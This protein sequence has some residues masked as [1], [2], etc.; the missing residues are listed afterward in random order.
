M[1]TLGIKAAAAVLLGSVLSL[2]PLPFPAAAQTA[3]SSE[4]PVIVSQDDLPRRFYPMATTAAEL[5]SA[6]DATFAAWAM[7]VAADADATLGGYVIDDPATRRRLLTTRTAAEMIAG[8]NEAALKSLLEARALEQK[9]DQRLT[10]GLTTEAVLRARLETGAAAG[11]AFQA[12]FGRHLEAALA[13]LPFAVV[14][15]ALKEMKSSAEIQSPS[16]IAGYVETEV[17][18]AVT[19]SGGLSYTGADDLLWARTATR[20]MWPV[21]DATVAALRKVITANAVQKPDIWAARDL[22]L[23]GVGDLTPVVAAVWDSGVDTALFPGQLYAPPAPP[24]RGLGNGHGLSFDVDSNPT[25][26]VLLPLTPEQAKAYPG[27]IADFQGFADNRAAIDSPAAERLRAKLAAMPAGET[28]AYFEQMNFFG[29]YLHGT[30]VAGILARDNPAL[31]LAVIRDTYDTRP[32]PAP[33][34]DETTAA[35]IAAFSD[36]SAWLKAN[37]VRVVNMSWIDKPDSY[38]AVLEKNGIGRDQAERKALARR[39]FERSRD[40]FVRLLA[41][42]PAT[43]FVSAAGNSDSD[44]AFEEG[45]PSSLVAPNLIIASAVDQAGDETSFTSNGRNVAVTANGYQ[46]VSWVPGGQELAESGTSMASPNVAN[47]A[48][49]LIALRPSLTPEQTIALIR[50]GATPSADGRR[51]NIN[52]QASAALLRAMPTAGR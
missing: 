5:L 1:S 19:T 15:T 3:P 6:D 17:E 43:L 41:D 26:G 20:I 23:T 28:A 13:A 51:R 36:I 48:A 52:P 49:K 2:A 30:H 44:N 21:R 37:K 25:D 33:P 35:R 11:P 47:L 29:D 22:K 34:T 42:N 39:Y 18:P 8:R 24:A 16:L 14:G 12:S 32:I 46:V 50:D 10:S 45:Y 27:M 9:P 4:K 31:R 7:Q 38:E 40:A